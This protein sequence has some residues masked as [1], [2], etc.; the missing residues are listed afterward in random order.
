M[1]DNPVTP[2]SGT[3]T[4][5]LWSSRDG[6]RR[7]SRQ[8][9]GSLAAATADHAPPR[10]AGVQRSQPSQARFETPVR[11]TAPRRTD[12][13]PS[14]MPYARRAR[15]RWRGRP[16]R[17][18]VSCW[19]MPAG[20]VGDL[21]EPGAGADSEADAAP[22]HTDLPGTGHRSTA[23]AGPGRSPL[24]FRRPAPTTRL[25]LDG[26]RGRR[27]AH[28]VGRSARGAGPSAWRSWTHEQTTARTD[29]DTR[30]RPDFGHTSTV[31]GHGRAARGR[32]RGRRRG[33]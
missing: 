32:R 25:D 10:I 20:G 2:G 3:A 8:P 28:W 24:P 26:C 23:S 7:P 30:T 29:L 14:T 27:R 21:R 16:Q 22:A 6:R 4:G 9:P 17:P 33:R 31:T 1:S 19:S 12:I 11:N 5:P 15:D 13:S 18:G